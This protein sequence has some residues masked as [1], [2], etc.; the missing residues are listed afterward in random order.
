MVGQSVSFDTMTGRDLIAG[1]D[2]GD[3]YDEAFVPQPGGGVVP[4]PHYQELIAQLADLEVSDLCRA[5]DL[6]NRS[7][8]DQGV[9][10]TVYSDQEQGTERVFPF[11][12]IPRL[13][14]PGE[15]RCI[16]TGL[17]QRIRA[18]NLF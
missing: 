17:Q 14:P 1:Y 16:E 15:W 13:I 9:T 8:L 5:S 3:F 18:L 11:D 6:A 4:R 12:L 7:F 10:F 2:T